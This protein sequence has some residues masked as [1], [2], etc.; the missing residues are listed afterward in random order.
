M[1]PALRTR[2]DGLARRF[3]EITALLSD[4]TVIANQPRFRDL[5]KEYAEIQ[6]LMA[7]FERY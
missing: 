6:P 4:S 3:E 5:S 1:H 7:L 2:L